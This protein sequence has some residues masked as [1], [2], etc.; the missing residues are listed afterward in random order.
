[1]LLTRSIIVVAVGV[2]IF[3]ATA[4]ATAV[5]LNGGETIG[6]DVGIIRVMSDPS[7]ADINLDGRYEGRTPVDI[8]VYVTATP[9]QSIIVSKSGYYSKTVSAPHPGAGEVR[10]IF[11]TLERKEP[12]ASTP[13]VD[14]WTYHPIHP[15]P[16]SGL[17]AIMWGRPR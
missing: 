11:V 13:S 17:M 7:G 12:P 15:V 10:E 14:G 16:P 6:G 3:A 8:R 9:P 1:M 2:L 4:P 5:I